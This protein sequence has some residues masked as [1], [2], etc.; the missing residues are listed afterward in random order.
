MKLRVPGGQAPPSGAG[1]SGRALIGLGG[2]ARHARHWEGMPE[3]RGGFSAGAQGMGPRQKRARR[4][5]DEA[6]GANWA[7][8]QTQRA[9]HY[10]LNMIDFSE[11]PSRVVEKEPI[12]LWH[13]GAEFDKATFEMEIMFRSLRG[14]FW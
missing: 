5:A 10:E 6:A 2:K 7:T 8:I 4:P 11:F 9:P 14:A 13:C 3:S 1:A 12:V